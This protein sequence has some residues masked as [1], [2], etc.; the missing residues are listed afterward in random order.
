MMKHNCLNNDRGAALIT[1]LVLL[2]IMTLIGVT[3]MQTST[4]EERMAGNFEQSD[5]A[6]QAAEA[7][8]RDAENWIASQVAGGG[9]PA[10][11]DTG[12]GG[13]WNPADAGNPPIWDASNTDWEATS[14]KKYRDYQAGDLGG[15][16]YDPPKYT[17]EFLATLNSDSD[18]LAVDEVPE[19]FGMYR[20]T[21]RGVSPNNRSRVFL[22][23]T[24]L[25]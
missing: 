2:V 19:E 23:T 3:A 10:F 4:L 6:F 5:L 9:L 22:Q 18:S 21:S 13:L 11:N 20:V 1:G 17:I 14:S 12:T 16:P 24:F 25:R 8:L 15:A 7:G